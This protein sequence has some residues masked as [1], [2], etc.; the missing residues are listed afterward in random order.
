M[1]EIPQ[2]GLWDVKVHTSQVK[3][4]DVTAKLIVVIY[5]D[6]GRSA[7][8]PLNESPIKLKRG[9]TEQFQVCLH[10]VL[11]PVLCKLKS[12]SVLVTPAD[13]N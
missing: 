10:W 3:N 1:I 2:K 8:I 11:N 13:H 9:Q 12:T 4:P 5:G 6:K 7:E